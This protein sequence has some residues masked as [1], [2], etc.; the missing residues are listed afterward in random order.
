MKPFPVRALAL[1]VMLAAGCR[2]QE[3]SGTAPETPAAEVKTA[4]AAKRQVALSEEITG[5]VRAR[6]RA[7][8]E[9]R[10]SG[11][12]LRITAGLGQTVKAGEVLAVLDAEETKARVASAAAALEQATRDERRAASLVGS[13][14]ISAQDYD[15]AKARMDMAKAAVSEAETMMGYGEVTAPFAGVITRKLADQGELAAPGKPLLELEDPAQL[16]IEAD[17]PESL[18]ARLRQ[19][20]KLAVQSPGSPDTWAAVA[21]ISPAG[22]PNSRTFPVKLDLPPDSGLRPGQFVRLSVPVGESGIVLIPPAAL[23]RRGQLEIVFVSDGG[24]ARLRLVRTGRTRTEGIEVLAGLDGTE[25]VAVT[26][27]DRLRDGQPLK[28]LP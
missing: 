12:I 25:S 6:T 4:A 26:G 1:T 24:T 23:L 9:A 27:V 28:I 16:R 14:A 7:V 13:R 19:G 20:Q 2:R 22:D 21:E 10:I 8:I 15:A 11:R 18:V 5:T 17:V 3:A